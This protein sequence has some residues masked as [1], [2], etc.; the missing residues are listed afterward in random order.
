MQLDGA[1]ENLLHCS[2]HGDLDRLDLGHRTGIAHGVHQPGGLEHQQPQRFDGDA[3]LGEPFTHHALVGKWPP[4]SDAVFRALTHEIHGALGHA[5]QPH[6]VVDAPRAESSLGDCE[7]VSLSSDE[8]GRGHP[9]P[10]EEHLGVAAVIP[11]VVAEHRQR[12]HDGDPRRIARHQDHALLAM[13]RG[14]RLRR[15]GAA[16]HDEDLGLGVHGPGRPPLA[17]GD[18]VVITVAADARRD[19]GGIGGGHFRLGHAEGRADAPFE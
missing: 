9:H 13:A 3:A 16:H 10:V 12:P 17:T 4:E 5:E 2:R 15:R 6:T 11:V 19:V 14:I 8:V 18:H 1:V 7:P